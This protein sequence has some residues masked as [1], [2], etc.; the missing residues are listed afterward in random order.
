MIIQ[1]IPSS[2]HNSFAENIINFTFIF[3]ILITILTII[4]QIPL[5]QKFDKLPLPKI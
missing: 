1:T 4:A 3:G 5:V 2:K